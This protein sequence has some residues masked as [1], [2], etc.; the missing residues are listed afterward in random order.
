MLDKKVIR[1][2]LI[3]ILIV[4]LI[5][6]GI[7]FIRRAFSRYESTAESSSNTDMALWIVNEGFTSEDL[8][9]GE[10]RPIPGKTKGNFD[11]EIWN[12]VNGTLSLEDF[13]GES[14]NIGSMDDYVK[15]IDFSIQNYNEGENPLVASVPLRYEVKLTTTT[16]MPLEYRLYQYNEDGDT[17]KTLPC[18][19]EDN[20]VEDD[21]GTY[22]REIV[23]KPS[24]AN[25]NDFYLD[26]MTIGNNKEK[27]K[28]MLVIWMPDQDNDILT[29]ENEN[30]LF[31]D[32]MD[33]LKIE[34]K[35]EQKMAG[36][37]ED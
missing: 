10:I 28:F 23:A 16:Y 27:D 3:I 32:L 8:Y 18:V 15:R 24:E 17:I 5:L 26:T 19:V 31:A 7:K 29:S 25:G 9:I 21:D 13:L 12:L 22:Y 14:S 1:K 20:I 4:F 36:D 30:Y 33:H 35:A 37:E 34:I 11:A 6:M 2:S